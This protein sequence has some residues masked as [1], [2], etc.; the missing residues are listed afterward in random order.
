[1]CALTG[2]TGTTH[3]VWLNAIADALSSR[4]KLGNVVSS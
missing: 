1:M 3:E 4:S 2:A